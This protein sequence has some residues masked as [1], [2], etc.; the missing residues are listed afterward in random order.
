MIGIDILMFAYGARKLASPFLWGGGRGALS[1]HCM[2][3]FVRRMPNAECRAPTVVSAAPVAS[4]ASRGAP[5]RAIAPRRSEASRAAEPHTPAHCSAR[6]HL[7]ARLP[8]G[9]RFDRA[10]KGSPIRCATA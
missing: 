3:R 10:H 7:I 6:P 4:R 2:S 1:E 9:F 8:R 5:R